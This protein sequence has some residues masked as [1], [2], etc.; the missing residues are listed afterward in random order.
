MS[1]LWTPGGERP[2][3]RDQP[4]DQVPGSA[5][6]RG[7]AGGAAGPE[8]LS[9]EEQAAQLKELQEQLARTPV[10]LV[11]ANHA[12]GLFELAALHLSRQPPQLDQAR[13]AIDGLAA[14]VEGLAGRLGDPERQL[15]EG[16]A[17]LRL[18]FVQIRGAQHADGVTDG[19]NAGATDSATDAGTDAATGDEPTT[20]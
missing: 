16:L 1:T 14:L 6:E 9:P 2:I 20:S 8:Q 19:Q 17:Q 15:K 12:F 18:A 5:A 4:E 7:P 11:I 13:L 3:R 10:E